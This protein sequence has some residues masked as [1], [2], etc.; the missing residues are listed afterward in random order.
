MVFVSY[1]HKSISHTLSIVFPNA[2]YGACTY[3]VKMNI[4]H[5]FKTDHC[6]KEYE[7]AAQTYQIFN[8]NHHFEKIKVKN[9]AIAKYSKEI[10]VEIWS[11]AFF[12]GIWYNVMIR[13]YVESFNSKSREARRYLITTF[14]DFLR[15]T[16][17]QWF[18]E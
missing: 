18:Y 11:R 17:Q 16:L 9:H 3:H 4:N 7:L 10:G 2:H 14:V 1:R 12:L 6:E 8:F 13:N 15:F 5:K